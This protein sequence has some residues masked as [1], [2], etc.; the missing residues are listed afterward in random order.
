MW[1]PYGE[2]LPKV[3]VKVIDLSD[4]DGREGFVQSRSIHVYGRADRKHKAGHSLVHLVVFL[5]AFK[6]DG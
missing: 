3:E 1:V 4:E 2:N 5:Q 6:G